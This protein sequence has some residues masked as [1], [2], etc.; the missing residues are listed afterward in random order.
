MCQIFVCENNY[1][2]DEMLEKAEHWNDDG[3]GMAW[4]Q[5]GEGKKG[6]NVQVH[7]EKGLS[8]KEVKEKVKELKRDKVLPVVIHFR[9]CSSGANDPQ[10]THPFPLTKEVQTSLTGE[11][12]AVLFH[13]G[14]YANWGE[15]MKI[16]CWAGGVKVPGGKW[17]DTRTLAWLAA[18]RGV[19]ALMLTDWGNG[20]IAVLK[21][22]G[23]VI[24][25]GENWSEG[26]PGIWFSGP[27]RDVVTY[28][29]GVSY[30]TPTSGRGGTSTTKSLSPITNK[31]LRRSELFEEGDEVLIWSDAELSQIAK[32]LRDEFNQKA[33]QILE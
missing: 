11:A 3:A 10:M 13:N 27:L 1:P 17:N 7:W 25:R 14:T 20:R 26:S 19:N 24:R 23:E 22:D 8:L 28:Q 12:D 33:M 18:T 4:L 30:T 32:E 15:I 16:L 6:E 21:K 2:T 29:R 9:A 5:E 31:D